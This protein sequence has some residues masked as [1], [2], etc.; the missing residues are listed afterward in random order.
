M[1]WIL[2]SALA[3]A[4]FFPG[5]AQAQGSY[6]QPS[7]RCPGGY[8][9]VYDE[10]DDSGLADPNGNI[11]VP[12]GRVQDWDWLDVE[13]ARNFW[14]TVA[15]ASVG[16]EL[17]ASWD[18]YSEAQADKSALKACKTG[19]REKKI[20]AK[21]LLLGSW[22]NGDGVVSQGESGKY[23]IGESEESALRTCGSAT[24]N[25]TVVWKVKSFGSGNR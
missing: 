14:A 22:A 4:V 9:I 3:A 6:G 21:C 15:Y 24:S 18:Q 1:K 7:Q 17:F 13:E 2:L 11:C 12:A 23:F 10:H 5:Q 25:C 19:L 20:K 16:S 8:V